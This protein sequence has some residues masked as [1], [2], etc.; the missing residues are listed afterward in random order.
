MTIACP[1]LAPAAAFTPVDI[2][3]YAW[4]SEATK[5][6]S[7]AVCI[8]IESIFVSYPSYRFFYCSLRLTSRPYLTITSTLAITRQ[9]KTAIPTDYGDRHK[10]RHFTTKAKHPTQWSQWIITITSHPH[11]T[12]SDTWALAMMPPYSAMEPA[13]TT[14]VL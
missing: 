14:M 6:L 3:W 13:A 1:A 10:L 5:S 12:R 8:W 11:L 2:L 9:A 4:L 7:Q